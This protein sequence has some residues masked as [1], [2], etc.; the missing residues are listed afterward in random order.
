MKKEETPEHREKRHLREQKELVRRKKDLARP[1]PKL[2]LYYLFLV[3][4]LAYIVD[5]IA[6]N[7]AN[8]FQSNIVTDFFVTNMGME[9]G[10]GLSLYQTIGFVAALPLFLILLYKP[11]AD[12]WGRKPF[13]VFNT[14]MMGVGLFI[15]YLSKDIV[16]FMVGS[17]LITF[18]V[19]HDVHVIYIMEAAPEKKRAIVYSLA[20]GIAV[21]G[22]LLVPWM[23][24][25]FMGN[26][27]S[28]WHLVFLVPACLGF[29]VAFLALI[30]ARESTTF[31]RHRIDYLEKTDEER[32]ADEEKD[33][34]LH[35]Q[36]G[37]KAG[38]I[39]SFKHKQL[40]NLMIVCF[41]FLIAS[42]AT[43]TYQSVMTKSALMSE[44][45]ITNALYLYPV[46]NAIFT[47]MMGFIS[48]KW[49]RKSSAIAMTSVAIAAYAL[50][51]T[52]SLVGFPPMLMGFF[53]GAFVGAYWSA[54]D[55]ID[56]IM[57]GESAPTNL[58]SS[59]TTVEAI[60][61]FLGGLLGEGIAMLC[62]LFTPDRYL[63]L[64]YFLLVIPG[65]TVAL[66]LLVKN[67]G[68]TKGVN[69]DTVT[70]EEW[71]DHKPTKETTK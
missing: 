12:K 71:D 67:V 55:T 38:L 7:I 63:G 48:D 41:F 35:A 10:A 18:F 17:T 50:F 3:V 57:I 34:A 23:R 70:G 5:E 11:L 47:I 27:S 16:V 39:F 64:L 37:I 26:D 22:T 45:D 1:L 4:S 32:S 9:Y 28:K 54:G 2:Y 44:E 33:K 25:I 36:G 21:L 58:R 53:I 42:V 69:L 66:V 24:S 15:I 6:S 20:K 62:Q 8:Q 61:F 14:L 31:L 59:C 52:G 19:T 56:S 68:E 29:V 46:G 51:F 43:S 13:L 65:M 49:G 60:I 30:T 40:R